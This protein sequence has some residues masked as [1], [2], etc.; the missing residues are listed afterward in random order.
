[1]S[2]SINAIIDREWHNALQDFSGNDNIVEYYIF[3]RQGDGE[4]YDDKQV[5]LS[6]TEISQIRHTFGQ[7]SNITGTR[8]IETSDYNNAPINVYSVSE[9]DEDD[10]VG[11][12]SMN[13]GWYDVTWKNRGG[14][15][16]TEQETLTLIHEI[17]HAAGL[18]HPNG[19]GYED[20]WDDTISVMSYN[21]GD[22]VPKTFRELDI[23]ALQSLFNT[24]PVSTKVTNFVNGNS[25]DNDL[26]GTDRP[27]EV[28]GYEGNDNLRANLGADTILGGLG[29]DTVRGGNGRDVLAG[30][31]GSDSI[32]GGFGLNTYSD[33]K[34]GS[35]D[36]IYI[37]SDQFAINWLY[38]YTAGNNSDGRKT[39]K[40]EKIDSFDE[41]FI[42]GVETNQL[43]FAT[44]SH[45]N[46]LGSLNGIGIYASG[47]LE[48][49]Y[50][51]GDLTAAQ[52]QSMTVGVDA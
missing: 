3:K 23:R 26:K 18:D 52:L 1:M 7:L 29:N 19:D 40:I 49:V 38:D 42:Q 28:I 46:S 39:D 11:E 13:D 12:T 20:G 51:G 37:K 35:I 36:K 47:F 21:E 5:A 4:E 33:E 17:G 22:F 6:L 43:T 2:F 9:Y 45:S 30:S 15:L 10:T 14:G 44:V 25:N 8:F 50:T 16:M 27:D 32:Y 24:T 31:E 41:I 34:D 48:A